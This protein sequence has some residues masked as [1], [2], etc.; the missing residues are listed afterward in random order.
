[1]P[2]FLI[3]YFESY[4]LRHHLLVATLIG[5]L[6][7]I[8]TAWFVYG[9]Q[10]MD[11]YHHGVLPAWQ[12]FSGQSVALPEYRSYLLVWLLDAF[13]LIATPF[14]LHSGLSM[15]RAM[16]LGLGVISLLAVL[17][18]YFYVSPF[19]SRLFG[20]LAIYLVALHPVMPFIG[21]RAF[22][23]AVALSFVVLGIGILEYVRRTDLRQLGLLAVSGFL[24]LGLATLFRYQS[25][26]IFVVYLIVLLWMR[27]WRLSAIGG[28]TGLLI[29]AAE[30]AIDL[31]G[32]REPLS[33]LG[34]YLQ[35][36]ANGAVEFGVMP[37]YNT[38][39]FM[40]GLTLFP[41]SLV[42]W[43]QLGR[44]WREHY[45]M[46]I[47]LLVFIAIHSLVPHKEERF[48]YPAIG[49]LW[50]V[51]AAVWSYGAQ[52]RSVRWLYAPLF[53]VFVI[54]TMPLALFSNT[55]ASDIEPLAE[56]GRRYEKVLFVDFD[57]KGKRD[58]VR[59]FFLQPPN[60]LLHAEVEP[61][62]ALVN[63]VLAIHPDYFAVVFLSSRKES[64]T[65]LQTAAIKTDRLRCGSLQQSG[66]L[67]DKW[68]YQL[69]SE[70]NQR[71]RQKWHLTCE[72]VQP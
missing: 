8:C 34:A 65:A 38:W 60:M 68:L 33:T 72:L 25:G 24:A 4:P 36:N 40:L 51:L 32:G 1:M 43:N 42:F 10:A 19:K 15:V 12:L 56:A 53:T 29:L 30:M 71:R 49:L 41:F 20:A 35:A 18:A 9:P 21:T 27:Q 22:G 58:I 55:Q 62:P 31:L 48:L 44:L 5:L 57:D 3:R 2:N 13:L 37:W 46:L 28:A 47:V 59:A 54:V 39:L 6:L 7:R 70:F 67:V 61:S 50:L 17:G 52:Q 23:E 26:L 63:N 14:E 66:S 45:P 69:N 11:D 64:L 16:Y